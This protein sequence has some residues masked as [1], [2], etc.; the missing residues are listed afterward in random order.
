MAI[1]NH[2]LPTE[3]MRN[4]SDGMTYCFGKWAY[5][6]TNGFFWIFGLLGFCIAIY[7]ASIRY[8]STRA[9]GFASFVG[10]VGSIFL[11]TMQFMQWWIASAFILVGVIGIAMM[12]LSER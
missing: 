6:V 12:I 8:G 5:N 10:M 9:F 3:L 1:G 7:I 11:A 4:C 2:T